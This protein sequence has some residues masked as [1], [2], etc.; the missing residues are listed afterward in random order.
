MRPKVLLT[1]LIPLGVILYVTIHLHNNSYPIGNTHSNRTI[2]VTDGV[3]GVPYIYQD[4]AD[5]RFIVLTYNRPSSL[6]QCLNNL[7]NIVLDGHKGIIEIWVD[8][9]A[10]G[11]I[12][13][14]TLI[15][16]KSFQWKHGLTRVHLWP[17]HVGIYGQWIDTWR[18]KIGSKEIAIFIEDDIDLSPFA[19]RWLL[20]AR[21][22][23]NQHVDIDSF[24]LHADNAHISKGP[25]MSQR[26]HVPKKNNKVFL[27]PILNSWGM[28]PVPK[29]WRQFQDW[30]HHVTLTNASYHPYTPGAD[31][32]TGWYKS[33]EKQKKANSMWTI[34]Y[35]HFC[36]LHHL[37]TVYPN[38][39]T[40]KGK[41]LAVNRKSPGLHYHG[42][43]LVKTDS[44][45]VKKWKPEFVD[46]PKQPLKY[47]YDGTIVQRQ[48]SVTN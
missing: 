25:R 8:R 35:I 6:S 2:I 18:P 39:D 5:V 41:S 13:N 17:R 11:N 32:Q 40:V 48:S 46:F 20:A 10:D 3:P 47:N 45:L 31:L 44:C 9:S 19:F 37:F 15:L 23:Y 24:S 33:F 22:S 29:V 42:R 16:A 4:E 30:F 36:Y 38:L 26:L 28:A 27:F 1:C 43:S 12:H 34:W 7:Q 21:R 14:A